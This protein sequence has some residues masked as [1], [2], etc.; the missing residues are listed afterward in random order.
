MS[1]AEDTAIAL[2]ISV[3]VP[4]ST[5]TVAKVI[6]S[7]VPQG[8]S[9]SNGIDNGDGSWTLSPD[10]LSGLS[11]TPPADFNGSLTLQVDA[12][13]TDGGHSS[14]DVI[15]SVTPEEDAP[16]LLAGNVSGN[17]DSAI[18][19]DISAA[20][21]GTETVATVVISGVPAGAVLSA[22]HD[23][24][25]GSWTV[26]PGQVGDL[27]ITPP[28]DYNGSFDLTVIAVSSDGG[29]S[30][31][32]FSVDAIPVAD[33][34]VLGLENATGAE[35]TAIDLNI[36]ADVPGLEDV[37]SVTIT[38]VPQGAVLSAGHDNGDGSWTLAPD[39]IDDLKIT[40][41]LDFNGNFSLGV[42]ATSTDG[43]YASG[44][45]SVCVTPVDDAASVSTS[46]AQ[47]DE[48]TAIALNIEV[49][50][51]DPVGSLVIAGLPGGA[52]LAVDS[53]SG[54]RLVGNT[55]LG[56]AA[57]DSFTA[58]DIA[59]L[60]NG[61]L[62]VTP[63]ENSDVD[64]E[65]TV[66]AVS[67]N[68]ESSD[69]VGL[70]VVVDAVADKPV[71]AAHLGEGVSTG[72]GG[73]VGPGLG[74]DIQV[75]KP[76]MPSSFDHVGTDRSDTIS[77][78]GGDDAIRGG[79]KNDRVYGDESWETR[80]YGNDTI[81]GED[82][83]DDIIGGDGHDQLS[84]GDGDDEIYGDFSWDTQ[85]AGNDVADGGD[86]NDRIVGG[87]G[88]DHISGG[89]GNDR[90]YGDFSWATDSAGDDVI[91]GGDGND[92]IVGGD[93]NDRI[94]GGD[95]ND[96]IEGDFDWVTNGAGN[97]VIDA[98]DGNDTVIG[99]AGDDIIAG[100]D[101]N[102]T[103]YG[104]Y[105]GWNSSRDGNDTISGGK[106]NDTIRGGGGDDVAV[107]AG[108]RNEYEITVT[109]NGSV[110][111]KD[112]VDGR[113][114]TD[115]VYD[116]E[117]FR[118]ADGDVSFENLG[119]GVGGGQGSGSEIVYPLDI[120]AALTDTDGSET[121]SILVE[122]MPEGA[123]LSAGTDNGNGS[124][125]LS[126]ADLNGLTLTAGPEQSFALDISATSREANGSTAESRL[127]LMVG[128][129]EGET[130]EDPRVPGVT[131]NGGRCNDTLT[132]GDG[133][134]VINGGGGS[135]VLS[136][137]GGNDT[138]VFNDDG[139]WGCTT[140]YHA[141][142]PGVAG[143]GE[144]VSLRGLDRSYDVFDG[145]DGHDT[146]VMGDGN[147][148]LFLNDG[149]SRIVN[150]EEIQ[151]GDGNDVVDLTD[152]NHG[153]GDITVDGGRG[154][155]VVW[156][157]SGN[158]ELIGGEGNDRLHG[159]SGNDIL[160]GGPGKDHVSGGAGDDV[161]VYD[162]QEGGDDKLEGGEGNDILRIEVDAETFASQG[163]QNELGSI[164]SHVEGG[165]AQETF[166]IG[167]SDVTISG[168]EGVQVYVDG[169]MTDTFGAGAQVTTAGSDNGYADGINDL[170]SFEASSD[171]SNWVSAVE[172][173]DEVGNV[174][175][176]DWASA[177]DGVS[178]V[179]AEDALG[180]FEEHEFSGIGETGDPTSDM[181]GLHRND[182]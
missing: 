142:D 39:Q 131:L 118:F 85:G 170:F 20:V 127:Q 180:D 54:L 135:D 153:Y 137:G 176:V 62:T 92:H 86:G 42:E 101:G 167:N 3:S 79:D 146:L 11:I 109:G 104:D 74:I 156:T 161:I 98:G 64:F 130:P 129:A 66:S 43:G 24:G 117:T 145:G 30:V 1:G 18:T 166:H 58:G 81:Y 55:V 77:G 162:V 175:G 2:G 49:T 41:S 158:D 69:P 50:A 19:L 157:S 106:G 8:A 60:A 82:G 94:L 149:R 88:S 53:A 27:S 33:N 108:N 177:V 90:I 93:G 168:F 103:I 172:G 35:D 17:E 38:G 160:D 23:N 47:G 91:D 73:Y 147:E 57:D 15:V 136:G 26:E 169:A 134:D 138:L 125:S 83:N 44:S 114:G 36:S 34:P 9:L 152:R 13:S 6:I 12:T 95:G 181:T 76:A 48:D 56:S 100:G 45:L 4:G 63:P 32:D 111:I 155:D 143:T 97:D 67:V 40:P 52:E 68:G 110:I 123:F 133:D 132:G 37:A 80:G 72:G 113:D 139:Q 28:A 126:P 179:S 116:V 120:Q 25:D 165:G 128:E 31:A 178:E 173:M 14:E 89:D 16:V 65:I 148:A 61:A 7:G 182:A 144:Q 119:S 99:G 105:T 59:A 115:K 46:P 29:T 151:A 112:L 107:Y 171:H 87:D 21:S 140:A 121:L 96:Y 141:G 164:R 102:D 84:G 70:R 71:L 154:D 159:G 174:G 10:Q 124:W 122:G 150:V 78:G 22:G 5:E 75:Q 51:G 163:L